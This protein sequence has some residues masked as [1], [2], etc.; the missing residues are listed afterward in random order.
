MGGYDEKLKNF[1]KS[2]KKSVIFTNQ[3]ILRQNFF[4]KQ[5]F[6]IV[7]SKSSVESRI[8]ERAFNYA[9]GFANKMFFQGPYVF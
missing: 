2:K 8:S 5:K 1:R 6:Q 9:L 4:L 7:D 3:T